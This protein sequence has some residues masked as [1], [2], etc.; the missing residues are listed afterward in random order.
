MFF[1]INIKSNEYLCVFKIDLTSFKFLIKSFLLN[2][3]GYLLL[4][5]CAI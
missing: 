5:R 2:K 1:Q 4:K 3:L